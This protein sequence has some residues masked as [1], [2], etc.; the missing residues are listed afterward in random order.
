MINLCCLMHKN[1]K[2]S[3][4]GVQNRLLKNCVLGIHF[5]K[6]KTVTVHGNVIKQ[7]NDYHFFLK[8][9]PGCV[10]QPVCYAKHFSKST[11]GS[12]CIS[13]LMADFFPLLW[14]ICT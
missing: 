5:W 8:R 9:L 2:R 3:A 1:E 7:R 13:I 6:E 4:L 10:L 11:L 12:E 14:L